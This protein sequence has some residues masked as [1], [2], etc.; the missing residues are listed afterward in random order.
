MASP[1]SHFPP[2]R[3]WL[4]AAAVLAVAGVLA[5]ALFLR[6]RPSPSP[7]ALP[8]ALRTALV[9]Q[10][11]R[12][13]LTNSTA[14]FTGWV[15]ERYPDGTLQSRSSVTNGRLAGRSEAWYP[16]GQ[17][18]FVEHFVDGVS[19]GRRTRWHENG[20]PQSEA[21]VVNGRLQGLFRRWHP[22]GGLA[23]EVTLLDGKP[24]GVSRSYHPNGRLKAEV[25]LRQGEVVKR[26]YWTEDGQPAPSPSETRPALAGGQPPPAP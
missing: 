26:Q 4:V 8:E 22:D 25:E 14:P 11:G 10:D 18:Q 1:A 9:L 2:R 21:D 20:N 17:P 16:G 3:R 7:L 5:V 19:H 12:L 23:E 15:L 6:S 24:E 13:H